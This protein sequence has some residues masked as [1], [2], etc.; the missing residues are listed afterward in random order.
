MRRRLIVLF[1]CVVALASCVTTEPRSTAVDIAS[2]KNECAR[3]ASGHKPIGNTTEAATNAIVEVATVK[4][5]LD[6]DTIKVWMDEDGDGVFEEVSVR[7]IGVSTPER[8]KRGADKPKKLLTKLLL[9]KTVYLERQIVGEEPATARYKRRLLRDV[10]VLDQRTNE[11]IFVNALLVERGLA[12][13][14]PVGENRAWNK[15]LKE[16]Q[17]LAKKKHR[18]LWR[19]S[20]AQPRNSGRKKKRKHRSG[21]HGR[22]FLLLPKRAFFGMLLFNYGNT[23]LQAR[24]GHSRLLEREKDF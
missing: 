10:Y 16:L 11:R 13:V 23:I 3:E 4:K 2:Y 1:G 17:A 20:A 15:K 22:S 14:T 9:N 19:D 5:I 24:T 7:L 8:G 18:G 12:R 21:H 6:G